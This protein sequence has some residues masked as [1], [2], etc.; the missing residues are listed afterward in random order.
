MK[1]ILISLAIIAAIAG[2]VVTATTAYFSDTETSTGNTFTAGSIDLKIDSECSY[3]GWECVQGY[4]SYEDYQGAGWISTG[5]P[6]ACNWDLK[7]LVEDEGC[8]KGDRF[9]DFEDIKPGDYGENTISFHGASNDAYLYATLI[10][11]EDDDVTCVDPEID[12]EEAMS[13]TCAP[14]NDGELDED[15]FFFIWKD[16]GEDCGKEAG[17]NIY[18]PLCGDEFLAEGYGDDASGLL[19]QQLY[20]G[21]LPAGDTTYVG[22]AFCVG[23][24]FVMN[25]NTGEITCDGSSVGNEAQTDTFVVGVEFESVQKR[26]NPQP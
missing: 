14:G 22:V 20:L 23:Q 17:D 16:D 7:D 9:F 1:K 8:V 21:E 26:H 2:V 25:P 5:L 19:N 12:A 3:N 10:E 13:L 6:C 11:I 18:D 24:G 4:W 15:I